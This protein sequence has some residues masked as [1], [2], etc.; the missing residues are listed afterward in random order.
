MN[1]NQIK[2][3]EASIPVQGRVD[4][5]VLAEMVGYW[6]K[7]GKYVK[8]MSQLINW[9]MD[10]CCQVLKING[11]ISTEFD[12]LLEA[13][14]YLILK[15]L[16]Q[17]GMR[18]R[19]MKK[20]IKGRQLENLR[21]EGVYPETGGK[22]GSREYTKLH[23]VHSLEPAPDMTQPITSKYN[24][25]WEEYDKELKEEQARDKQKML[26]GLELNEDGTVKAIIT[27]N[28]NYTEKDRVRDVKAKKENDAA[29]LVK[30]CE[31]I[32]DNNVEERKEKHVAKKLNEAELD[33]EEERIAKKDKKML[34]KWDSVDPSDLTPTE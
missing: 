8:S 33:A 14:E 29:R 12:T 26:D 13:D 21:M 16:H 17:P 5:R 10:L 4:I 23:N 19:W 2:K 7:E 32:R 9:S 25:A 31:K 24:D 6:E 28:D 15:G 34:D 20:F 1:L 22:E 3:V 27:G 30:D 18:K 11:L